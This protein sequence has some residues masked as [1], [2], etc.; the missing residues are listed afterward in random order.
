M[1][2]VISVKGLTKRFAGHVALHDIDLNIEQGEFVI[3]LGP[4]GAGKTT[5]LKILETLVRPSYG[6]VKIGGLELSRSAVEIRKKIGAIS[7]ESY[8]YE[9]LTVEENLHFYGKM[10]GLPES[11]LTVR[12]QTLL[13]QLHLE[14]RCMDRVST[15]SR[16]MKQR[17]SIARSLIHDPDIILMDEPYTGLDLRSACDLDN[18]LLENSRKVTVLMVTHDLERAFVICDRVIILSAGKIAVDMRKQEIASVEELRN[19]YTTIFDGGP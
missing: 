6:S 5:L 19:I 2:S 13:E 4:N 15:L 16:G 11:E 10:Y 3:I 1:G 8:L 17:L 12:I 14:Q 7:H 9:D 18:M